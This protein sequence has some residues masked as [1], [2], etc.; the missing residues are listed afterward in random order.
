MSYTH[1]T[2]PDFELELLSYIILKIL[3]S[4]QSLSTLYRCEHV[5][6]VH[7]LMHGN[8]ILIGGVQKKCGGKG[9]A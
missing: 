8:L 5:N 7:G 3:K 1:K 6:T 4:E 9:Q 2:K